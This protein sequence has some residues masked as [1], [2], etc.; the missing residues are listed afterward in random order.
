MPT[1]SYRPPDG[2]LTLSQAQQRLGISKQTLQRMMRAGKLEPYA[3]PR[4]SRVTLL[5]ADDVE[6][7]MHPVPMGKAAA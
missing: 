1:R 7:L 2:Y 3:D 4:N 5:K 6:R